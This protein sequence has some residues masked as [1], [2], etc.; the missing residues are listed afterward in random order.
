MCYIF[1]F[2]SNIFL[3]AKNSLNPEVYVGEYDNVPGEKDQDGDPVYAMKGTEGVDYEIVRVVNGKGM[4]S[5]RTRS[6]GSKEWGGLIAMKTEAG[7]KFY[8]FAFS[9]LFETINIVAP[10]PGICPFVLV[11]RIFE[12]TTASSL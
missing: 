5:T 4:Y 7:T 8:P 3:S 9:L 2:R 10:S 11:S 1:S 6:V 12:F